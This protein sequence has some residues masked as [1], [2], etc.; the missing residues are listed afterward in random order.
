MFVLVT[1]KFLSDLPITQI[2]SSLYFF[3][4]SVVCFNVRLKL[5]IKE[6]V[7]ANSMYKSCPLL[8]LTTKIQL[9]MPVQSLNIDLSNAALNTFLFE[10]LYEETRTYQLRIAGMGGR[11]GGE[12]GR[13]VTINWEL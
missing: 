8:V 6:N 4:V 13:G 11:G 10:C 5:S 1:L 7:L 2:A 3:H 9:C 12:G